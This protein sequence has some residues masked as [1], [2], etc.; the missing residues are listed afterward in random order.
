MGLTEIG[1][2]WYEL[3]SSTSASGPV[4]GSCEHGNE[5]SGPITFW[6]ILK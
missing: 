6:E 1:W 5:L 4:Q 2:R 3:H